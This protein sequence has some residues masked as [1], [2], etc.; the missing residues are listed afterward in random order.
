MPNLKY[1]VVSLL[2]LKN[3]VLVVMDRIWENKIIKT[4]LLKT[5]QNYD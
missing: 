2:C 4:V 1:Q 3:E 5:L